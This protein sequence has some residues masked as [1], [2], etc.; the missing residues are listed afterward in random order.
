MRMLKIRNAILLIGSALL[1]GGTLLC[2]VADRAGI[3]FP[4]WMAVNAKHSNLEGRNYTK[5]PNA[6]IDAVMS[7][8][9]QNTFESYVADLIPMRDEALLANARMQRLSIVPMSVLAGYNYYPTFFGSSY[10]YDTNNNVVRLTPLTKEQVNT[11]ALQNSVRSINDFAQTHSE[12]NYLMYLPG[13][14]GSLSFDDSL[15]LVSDAAGEQFVLDTV[16]AD[17]IDNIPL[18]HWSPSTELEYAETYYNCDHHWK[19]NAAYGAYCTSA[20]YFGFGDSLLEPDSSIAFD[21]IE[22]YGSAARTG[23]DADNSADGIV[24]YRFTLPSYDIWVSGKA[25]TEDCINSH[26]RYEK[27][28]W[29]SE[30][31]SGYYADYYHK[32]Y[33]QIILVRDDD[34]SEKSL[35]IV[36]DSFSNSIERLYLGHYK[37]V[38][39]YDP[40]YAKQTLSEFVDKYNN[41]VDDVMCM[42]CYQTLVNKRVAENLR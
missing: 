16:S 34:A 26:E 4:D 10:C 20:S 8:K 15:G 2:T 5:L 37:K 25:E 35:L 40:R 28:E 31:F 1:L 24:D 17:L 21:Q 38:Y 18:Q 36:S 41:E 32:D 11:K 13:R 6:S 27:G 30:R 9:F 12:L 14:A 42:M 3:S 22:F 29:P 33:P 7:G 39:V 19:I 23:L